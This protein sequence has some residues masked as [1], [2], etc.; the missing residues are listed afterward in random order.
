MKPIIAWVLGIAV[1]FTLFVFL[2]GLRNRT[3]ITVFVIALVI[4]VAAALFL[5]KNP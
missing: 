5:R 4:G 3:T 1:V 2:G